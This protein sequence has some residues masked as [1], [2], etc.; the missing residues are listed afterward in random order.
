[1]RFCGMSGGGDLFDDGPEG[2]GEGTPSALSQ[3]LEERGQ[4]PRGRPKGAR[5]RKSAALEAWY[6][7]R[8]YRDPIAVLGEIVSSDPRALAQL[9]GGKEPM[10]NAIGAIVAAAGELAPYLHGKQPV[11]VEVSGQAL[12][13]LA[14]VTGDNQLDQARALQDRRAL[15]IGAPIVEG[16]ASEIKDLEPDE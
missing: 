3:A 2:D 7:A 5:N 15:S 14:I 1:M 12:P 8:G 6:F 11:K 16:E 13:I 10:K 9:I 4:A